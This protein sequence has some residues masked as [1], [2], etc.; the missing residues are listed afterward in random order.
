MPPSLWSANIWTDVKTPTDFPAYNHKSR[1]SCR[2]FMP[3]CLS[4]VAEARKRLAHTPDRHIMAY[5]N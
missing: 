5:S 2:Y 1:A 3:T 4:E